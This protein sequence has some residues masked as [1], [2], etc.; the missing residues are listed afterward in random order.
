[1]TVHRARTDE[2][3]PRTP[4]TARSGPGRA[5]PGVGSAAIPAATRCRPAVR[6]VPRGAERPVP[7]RPGHLARLPARRG[8]PVPTRRRPLPP[9]A[10]PCA[11]GSRRSLLYLDLAAATAL[12]DY[13]TPAVGLLLAMLV[14]SGGLWLADRW[15][16]LLLACGAIVAAAGDVHIGG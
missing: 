7:G 14:S 13:L 2:S 5:T 1:V 15:R 4:A 6:P 10:A 8:A 12:Y 9:L 11:R 16:S 3:V